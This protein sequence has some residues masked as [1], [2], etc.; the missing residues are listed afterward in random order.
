MIAPVR[1]RRGITARTLGDKFGVSARTVQRSIAQSRS[2]YLASAEARRT[3][4]VELVSSGASWDDI[5]AVL[6]C[7]PGAVRVMVSRARR[8]R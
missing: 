8:K 5:A 3:Q 4:A 6:G 7:S 1:R 2:D